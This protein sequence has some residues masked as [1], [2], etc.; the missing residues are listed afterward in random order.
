MDA[1]RLTWRQNYLQFISNIYLKFRH[2]HLKLNHI[3]L[4]VKNTQSSDEE[5]KVSPSLQENKKNSRL[6]K[7]D[8]V[9][10]IQSNNNNRR[11]FLHSGA[12]YIS[13]H[14]KKHHLG[15]HQPSGKQSSS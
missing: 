10:G 12:G 3:L 8:A 13:Q 15:S 2:I 6:F 7:V 14:N 5:M 11:P 1:N 9:D 4:T